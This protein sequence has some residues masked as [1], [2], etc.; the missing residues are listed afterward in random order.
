MTT[1]AGV[2]YCHWAFA[3]G[4]FQFTATVVV[5]IDHCLSVIQMSAAA[6]SPV[7]TV[8]EKCD[9]PRILVV[10]SPFSATVALFC[11]SVDRALDA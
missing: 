3:P 10:V 2:V 9:C 6:L 8:A 4:N 7:H 1:K 5:L 11:D